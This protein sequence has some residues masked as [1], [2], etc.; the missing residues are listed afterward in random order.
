MVLQESIHLRTVGYTLDAAKE[1]A[2]T[3]FVQRGPTEHQLVHSRSDDRNQQPALMQL[4]FR[5]YTDPRKM[6]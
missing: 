3:L 6:G 5:H 2:S 1:V 4:H